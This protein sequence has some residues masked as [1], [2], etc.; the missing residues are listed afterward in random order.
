VSL[1]CLCLRLRA[2]RT[3]S[4][5]A[6]GMLLHMCLC[7]HASALCVLILVLYMCPR[8]TLYEGSSAS[9]T[10]QEV[11]DAKRERLCDKRDLLY[12]K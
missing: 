11:L 6:L 1:C 12:E 7:P 5:G 3:P 8:T 10:L 4:V 9:F 2:P